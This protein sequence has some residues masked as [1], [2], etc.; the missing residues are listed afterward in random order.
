ML[1]TMQGQREQTFELSGL[2]RTT[3]RIFGGLL[4]STKAAAD[5]GA[6]W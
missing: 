2:L 6:G 1:A 5:D 4:S 3:T